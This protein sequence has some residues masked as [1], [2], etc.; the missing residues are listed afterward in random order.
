MRGM[1]VSTSAFRHS[2]SGGVRKAG[3]ASAGEAAA[4]AAMVTSTSRLVGFIF[5]YLTRGD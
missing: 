1:M 4:R 5:C 3:W 2:S